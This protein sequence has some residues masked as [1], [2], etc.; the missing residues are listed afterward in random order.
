[1]TVYEFNDF[2]GG[3]PGTKLS[4]KNEYIAEKRILC[5]LSSHLDISENSQV[6]EKISVESFL[7]DLSIKINWAP[8]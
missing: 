3:Q 2:Y 1:M 6:F 7:I 4:V 5:Y 8:K